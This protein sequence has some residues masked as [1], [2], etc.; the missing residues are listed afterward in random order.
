MHSKKQVKG[1]LDQ[2][3]TSS[4]MLYIQFSK[5]MFLCGSK[6]HLEYVGKRVK[7]MWMHLFL[8]I[9]HHPRQKCELFIDHP[10]T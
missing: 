5:T 6:V 7:M 2:W 1:L 3:S 9:V 4:Q 10:S 8:L